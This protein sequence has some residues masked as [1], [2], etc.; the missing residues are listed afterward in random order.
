MTSGAFLERVD[1]RLTSANRIQHWISVFL[2]LFIAFSF[3]VPWVA[4]SRAFLFAG[5][6][7]LIIWACVRWKTEAGLSDRSGWFA[8]G[9]VG[10]VAA[11]TFFPEGLSSKSQY[12]VVRWALSTAV[13]MLAVL[14]ASEK[15]LDKPL[16]FARILMGVVAVSGV[17]T[18]LFYLWTGQYPARLSG[19]GFMGHPILGPSALISVWAIGLIL[20][21]VS[22]TRESVDQAILTASFLVLFVVVI[23]AQSRGPLV[24]LVGFLLISLFGLNGRIKSW[25]LGWW[26]IVAGVLLGGGAIFLVDDFLARMLERGFS[27]R[28]QIWLAVIENPPEMIWVGEGMASEFLET[29]AGQA[30]IEQAGLTIK[31]PHSLFMSVFHYTGIIGT[32]LFVA[33]LTWILVRIC[34]LSSDAGLQLR[35]FA[36]A[37]FVLT[38][39]LNTT[40]GHRIVA[41]P[42]TDWMFSWL[43]LMFLI[44]L[45]RHFERQTA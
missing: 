7:P 23:L 14:V 20:Y 32:G 16:P 6:L 22:G 4:L 9:F 25:R 30:L 17:V 10:F 35:P 19:F 31:H 13:F 39:L 27:Y 21:R 29:G 24:A 38:L 45:A 28:P 33:L 2:L 5:V 1:G 43:P 26:L 3:L 8:I 37:L 11:A 15:W 41:P 36:L 18:L 44:A 34:R 12:Q 40:D 42:S